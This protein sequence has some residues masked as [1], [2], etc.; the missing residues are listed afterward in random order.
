MSET[1]SSAEEIGGI[2]P[3][4]SRELIGQLSQTYHSKEADKVVKQ[5]G[6]D[7]DMVKQRLQ[8]L[9][10]NNPDEY[11]FFVK[12]LRRNIRE[13]EGQVSEA[14]KG[15]F[16]DNPE[17]AESRERREELEARVVRRGE[18]SPELA[19]VIRGL[20]PSGNYLVHGTSVEGAL[21]V[22]GDNDGAI[23]SV[24][25]IRKNDEKFKGKGG[26]LGVSFSY[27][28]VRALPGTWRHMAMFVT[29]PESALDADKKLV[30]PYYAADRELQL[31]GKSYDRRLATYVES[32]L[33]FYG[34]KNL[35]G[36]G[37]VISDFAELENP[38]EHKAG[39]S[40]IE[41]DLKK[42]K[43]GELKFE[44]VSDKYQVTE[45]RLTVVPDITEQGFNLNKFLV[46]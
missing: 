45:G 1:G 32:T 35:L 2:K 31:V 27:D 9:T 13:N 34:L 20:F 17:T 37:G 15:F 12:S 39:E 11:R 40:P 4:D 10:D 5:V 6:Y 29:S 33:D 43:S 24:A 42:L 8:E 14:L 21:S 30:V 19:Q 36:G 41:R 28:G 26:Y 23:K 38:Y 46:C 44:D 3:K 7:N 25:E 16:S 22:A 18:I